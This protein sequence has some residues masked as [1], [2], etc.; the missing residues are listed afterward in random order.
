[1]IFKA[2]IVAASMLSMGQVA[3]ISN[4]QKTVE[5]LVMEAPAQVQNASISSQNLT[6]LIEVH[7]TE[8]YNLTTEQAWQAYNSGE[9]TFVE[10][11]EN[12]RYE[13]EYE[14]ILEIVIID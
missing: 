10:I 3:P 8:A 6:V 4:T 2:L 13:M 7:A 14:G 5:P 1:M 11:A 9:L 12:K